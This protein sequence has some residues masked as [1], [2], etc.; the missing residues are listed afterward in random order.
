MRNLTWFCIFHLLCMF[1]ANNVIKRIFANIRTF[2]ATSVWNNSF[3]TTKKVSWIILPL[4]LHIITVT[5][6]ITFMTKEK[7]RL[8]REWGQ[9]VFFASLQRKVC[10]V[11]LYKLWWTWHIY[12]ALFYTMEQYHQKREKC[13]KFSSLN[14]IFINGTIINFKSKQLSLFRLMTSTFAN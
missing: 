7:V 5:L 13:L 2:Q 14:G 8:K 1:K 12:Y 6:Q 3:S 10:L 4:F 11:F 9:S